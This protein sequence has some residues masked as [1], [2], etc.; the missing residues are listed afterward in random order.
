MLEKN[1]LTPISAA[2]REG[3]LL[4]VWGDVPF[5]PQERPPHDP[6]L[7]IE[8]WQE[9][10]RALPPLPFEFS[11]GTPWP[12]AGLPALPILSL[13]PSDRVETTFRYAGVPL[14]VMRTR[15]DPRARDRHSL[16]KLGGDLAARSGLFLSWDDVRAAAGNPDK[17]H[18]LREA[19]RL[20]QGG[21]VLAM[22]ESPDDAFARLWRELLTPALGEATHQFVLGPQ[23]F[24]WPAPLERLAAGPRE[25]LLALAEVA[26]PPPLEPVGADALRRQLFEARENLLLIEER[27]DEYPL[28]TDVPLSL[29]KE[30]RRLLQRIAE[31]EA[32]LR[33]MGIRD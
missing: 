23:R 24:D 18:L 27:E 31:L 20:V 25:A 10:A 15:R 16:L 32:R 26:V 14:H 30:K 11:H 28:S 9:A 19:R 2:L 1:A 33:G 17:A 7:L 4:L 5:A 29:V 6:A 22:V 13:D 3:R 21:V 12:L 8:R